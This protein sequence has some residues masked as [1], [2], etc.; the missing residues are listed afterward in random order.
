[1]MSTNLFESM[2]KNEK[3]NYKFG[4]IEIEK[5]KFHQHERSISIKTVDTN[6][7]VVSN[8]VSFG[9]NGFK[10]FI[11]YKDAK[12]RPLSI[13]LPKMSAYGRDFNETKH[14]IFFY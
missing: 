9:K 2:Y 3:N 10:Y 13:F 8:K 12:I 14:L 4:H 11:G 6:K 5:Q 7:M 1:M